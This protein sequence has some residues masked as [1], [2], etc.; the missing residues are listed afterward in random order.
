MLGELIHEPDRVISGRV[1]S[2]S[3]RPQPYCLRL[4]FLLGPPEARFRQDAIPLQ[5]LQSDKTRW[6]RTVHLGPVEVTAIAVVAGIR[7]QFVQ[8]T[9][10]GHRPDCSPH[11]ACR[12]LRLWR[13]QSPARMPGAICPRAVS[14]SWRAVISP[15]RPPARSERECV[16]ASA[17]SHSVGDLAIAIGVMKLAAPS[18]CRLGLL[19][20]G[21]LVLLA[22]A[23]DLPRSQCWSTHS[24]HL[25]RV[26]TRSFAS[27]SRTQ[28]FGSS[29]V[30]NAASYWRRRRPCS[31]SAPS[32]RLTASSCGEVGDSAGMGWR[33]EPTS[34]SS[35]RSDRCSRAWERSVGLGVAVS[36]IADLL[37]ALRPSPKGPLR[38]WPL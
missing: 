37:R 5:L 10:R 36:A 13:G 28:A 1:S 30:S 15:S 24:S 6:P 34:G 26:A 7:S 17:C 14:S 19:A 4:E 31:A 11:I 3:Q 27:H 20:G 8:A 12:R 25:A 38:S 22:G 21:H 23:V 32:N 35:A 18:C 16:Q 29:D 2:L 33:S 9:Q